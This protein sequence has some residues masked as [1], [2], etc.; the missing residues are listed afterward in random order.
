MSTS[1]P[2]G[3]CGVH[4]YAACSQRKCRPALNIRHVFAAKGGMV[5]EF[6]LP[7]EE[8]EDGGTPAPA[9]APTKAAPAP[10]PAPAPAKP[11]P[12]AQPVVKPGT[13]ARPRPTEVAP[14]GLR[15]AVMTPGEELIAVCPANPGGTE[16]RSLRCAS[17][18]PSRA[19]RR[20]T[21]RARYL[22]GAVRR[23]LDGFYVHKRCRDEALP[24]GDVLDPPC[25]R[26]DSA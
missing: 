13:A 15:P 4:Y 18:Q 6:D 1:C 26:A 7:P 12:A 24:W 3:I 17:S 22:H 25:C 14:K 20:E 23:L 5:G 9:P 19:L 21:R 10:A 2:C 8:E 16:R 11:K